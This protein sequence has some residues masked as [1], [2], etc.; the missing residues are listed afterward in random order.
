MIRTSG[1]VPPGRFGKPGNR[2]AV[3]PAL[4]HDRPMTAAKVRIGWHDLPEPVR[5]R[6]EEIIGDRVVSARSQAGGFSPGTADRVGTVS[7]RRAFVKAVTPAL[8][9]RSAELARQEMH[10]TAAIPEHAPVPR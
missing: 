9:P 10:I 7:G 6:V 1:V 2:V 8:N 3:R 4:C 5:S